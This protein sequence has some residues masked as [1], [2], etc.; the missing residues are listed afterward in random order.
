LVKY[1]V[2]LLLFGLCDWKVAYDCAAADSVTTSPQRRFQER[3]QAF[4]WA[5]D[6]SQVDRVDELLEQHKGREEELIQRV[7]MQVGVRDFTGEYA[8]DDL[9]EHERYSYLSFSWGSS[10]P[11]HLLPTDRRRWSGL[12]GTPSSQKREAVEPQLPVSWE[13]TSA[14]EIDKTSCNCDED[15]WTYAFDFTMVNVL[16]KRQGGRAKPAATDYVRRRRWIRRRRR[17]PEQPLTP[18]QPPKPVVHDLTTSPESFDDDDERDDDNEPSNNDDDDGGGVGDSSTSS[19]KP[20]TKSLDDARPASALPTLSPARTAPSGKVRPLGPAFTSTDQEDEK[21]PRPPVQ[22]QLF[23]VSMEKAAVDAAWNMMVKNLEMLYTQAKSHQD[24]KKKAFAIKKEKIKQQIH[25]LEKTIAS[26]ETFAHE[27]ER[28]N[29]MSSTSNARLPGSPRR[30]FLNSPRMQRERQASP[31]S[32]STSKSRSQS[33]AS[34]GNT[35]NLAAKLRRA[36]SKLDALKR[37]YWHPREK[38]YTLRFSVDGIFYGLRDFQIESFR[39]SIS[40]HLNHQTNGAQGIT[41][42]CKVVLK[43]HTVCCGKH[44]KV[45]GEKGTRV[46]KTIWERMYLDTEFDATLYLIYV[47]DVHEDEESG[48]VAGRW[49]FLFNA[50][51]SRVELTNFTRRVKGVDLPEPVVRKLCSDVLS[52]LLRDLAI[53]YFPAELAVMFNAPP[54]RMD[55]EGELE[56]TGPP[57]ESVLER[58]LDTTPSTSPTSAVLAATHLL[59]GSDEN[60]MQEIASLLNLTIPQL[61]LLVA[62]RNCGLYPT[63]YSFKSVAALGEYF[64]R[65]FVQERTEDADFVRK[66]RVTWKQALELV[67]IR[68]TQ[69]KMANGRASS[70]PTYEL[71]DMDELFDTIE[72]LASKPAQMELRVKRFQCTMNAFSVVEAMSK[73]YERIVLGIDYQR[74]RTSQEAFLYGFRFGRKNTVTSTVAMAAQGQTSHLL[75][76]KTVLQMD[77]SFRAQLKKFSKFCRALKQILELVQ[78]NMDQVHA[79]FTGKLKGLGSDCILDGTFRDLEFLGPV[80]LAQ[81]IPALFLGQYRLETVL[82]EDDKVGL[83]IELQLPI[84]SESKGEDRQAELRIVL[85]GASMDVVVDVDALVASRHQRSLSSASEM[86][87]PWS[88]T[89]ALAREVEG[90]KTNEKLSAFS[91]EFSSKSDPDSNLP[92]LP[93]LAQKGKTCGLVKISSSAF[94]KL[95]LKAQGGSFS[96]RLASIVDFV[97]QTVRPFFIDSFPE[98]QELFKSIQRQLMGWLCSA[99]MEME[100]DL[101]TK[102]FIH[103]KQQLFFTVCGS[104]MHSQ[105]IKYKDELLLLP[106]ILQL[107]DLVNTWIDD[108][109]PPYSNPMYF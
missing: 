15:G 61:N 108:R 107:D 64:S 23:S 104:P 106:L 76:P 85:I 98:H 60:P 97:L 53:L 17:L 29:R 72:R 11:G 38:D 45:V 7:H 49:E 58:E 79:E 30:S 13:W 44:V 103:D 39:S 47:E 67:Y 56:I 78:Q 50:D 19:T 71:F 88:P 59:G 91:T 93:F 40:I 37:M 101:I 63:P 69:A 87:A 2:L 75:D 43:G 41:P 52:S 36:Q 84:T 3:L 92:S 89:A 6:P 68:K 16:I 95:Q 55:F 25:L 5:H 32:A 33:S 94:T 22:L 27:E 77:A 109:Y 80:N 42:T 90:L 31:S 46:P 66:L 18:E 57:I 105:P 10:F 26:M 48:T 51:S 34:S 74:P 12:H 35:I 21:Q 54:G 1:E 73:L 24:L 65:Y 99:E 70:V 20:S 8:V 14:W 96:T 81:R 9:Y 102:A 28:R 82:L 86:T 83:A 62:L 100:F 4:F